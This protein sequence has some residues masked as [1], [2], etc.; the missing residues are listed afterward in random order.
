MWNDGWWSAIFWDFSV[1]SKQNVLRLNE[2]E[3]ILSVH[4]LFN[5][6]D[7]QHNL[8]RQWVVMVTHP[9][10]R[11]LIASH[12]PG[13]VPVKLSLFLIHTLTNYTSLVS[14]SFNLF[15]FLLC[16]STCTISAYFGQS[17]TQYQAS[18]THHFPTDPPGWSELCPPTPPAQSYWKLEIKTVESPTRRKHT[19]KRK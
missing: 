10:G 17:V 9:V 8:S 2:L 4:I 7:S 19:H 1:L 18:S 5:L 6:I 11:G 12:S 13:Q 14:S 3:A 15:S 16:F